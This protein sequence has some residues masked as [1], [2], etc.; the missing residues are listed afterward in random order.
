[1][2]KPAPLNIDDARAIIRLLGEV[3]SR[4]DGHDARK[5][6]LMD[7]LGGLID[8]DSWAWATT[9]RFESGE[10]PLSSGF[11]TGGFDA[12]QSAKFQEALEH[13]AHLNLSIHTVD[14][15]VK[16]VFRHFKV[17]SQPALIARFQNGDGGDT[18]AAEV[19]E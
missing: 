12:A 8:A 16:D 11:L 4:T 5:R 18:P 17:H 9:F 3:A 6:H 2:E 19:E 15:Y 7:G 10:I 1:M 14:G 13:P